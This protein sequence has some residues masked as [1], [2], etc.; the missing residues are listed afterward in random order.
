MADLKVSLTII[1]YQSVMGRR[2]AFA[3]TILTGAGRMSS[4]LDGPAGNIV[5]VAAWLRDAAA[6]DDGSL[7]RRHGTSLTKLL[8][9][10][11][12]AAAE[13]TPRDPRR[14][15]LARVDAALADLTAAFNA[16]PARRSPSR[17]TQARRSADAASAP[18]GWMPTPPGC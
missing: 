7:R 18:R 5:Q 12:R 16:C 4:A 8:I 2:L 11:D 15:S 1:T 13:M 3:C 6:E 17:R 10:R 9:L 14:A